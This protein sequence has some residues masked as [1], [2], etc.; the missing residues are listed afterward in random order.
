[1]RYGLSCGKGRLNAV[2]RKQR[3]AQSIHKGVSETVPVMG[4]RAPYLCKVQADG[5]QDGQWKDMLRGL[6]GEDEGIPEE[7]EACTDR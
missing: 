3:K 7:A 5:P 6:R 2:Q 4:E 1:M